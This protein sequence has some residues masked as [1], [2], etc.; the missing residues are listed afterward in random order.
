MKEIFFITGFILTVSTVLIIEKTLHKN[1]S[2]Q[3]K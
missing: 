1:T 3:T 2:N